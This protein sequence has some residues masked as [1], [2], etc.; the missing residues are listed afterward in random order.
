MPHSAT[1]KGDAGKVQTLD[2]CLLE[3][4]ARAPNQNHP[5]RR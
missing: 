3:G 1:K 5:Y 4:K 2:G